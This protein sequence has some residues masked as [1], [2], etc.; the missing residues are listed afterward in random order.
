[1]TP[2]R[3]FDDLVNSLLENACEDFRKTN[4]YC[5]LY[6]QLTTSVN[7][8]PYLFYNL[9]VVN[10]VFSYLHFAT[11]AGFLNPLFPCS[12]S[13]FFNITPFCPL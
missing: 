11:K 2:R 13:I 7:N 9:F 5:L 10:L 4:Q 12:L 3:N 1:M 6:N 8:F